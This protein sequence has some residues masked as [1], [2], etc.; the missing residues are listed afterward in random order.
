M[1]VYIFNELSLWQCISSILFVSLPLILFLSLPISPYRQGKKFWKKWDILVLMVTSLALLSLVEEQN[2]IARSANVNNIT[3]KIKSLDSQLPMYIEMVKDAS[4][5]KYTIGEFSP[6][7]IQLII[8]E[9]NRM[10]PIFTSLLDKAK[11]S[12][13]DL[14]YIRDNVSKL[15]SIDYNP[16]LSKT[17]KDI[18]NDKRHYERERQIYLDKEERSIW[19]G[20]GKIFAPLLFCIAI[21][22][23]IPKNVAEIY[24]EEPKEITI[25]KKYS[26]I[27]LIFAFVFIIAVTIYYFLI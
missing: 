8:D 18:I 9:G 24:L 22:L 11:L 5:I 16:S 26:N 25:N 2:R 21:A 12:D 15:R 27:V 10:C 7:D 6:S 23:R 3:N 1:E 19:S 14:D 4:C 13:A 17:I 20:Y